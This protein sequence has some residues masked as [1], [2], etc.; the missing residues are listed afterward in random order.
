MNI[1]SG[2]RDVSQHGL[3]DIGTGHRAHARSAAHR[4]VPTR[5]RAAQSD[6]AFVAAGTTKATTAIRRSPG[7][8]TLLADIGS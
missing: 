7:D 4:G 2:L 1:R 8:R 5:P 3:D 6:D